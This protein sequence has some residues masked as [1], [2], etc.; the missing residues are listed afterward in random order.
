MEFIFGASLL[1][2][3]KI[4]L[5]AL[6]GAIIGTE[7]QFA[8]KE[9]GIR[10]NSIVAI[11]ACLFS[12]VGLLAFQE[13]GFDPTR[14]ASNV[15]VGMGFIGGGIIIF[16]GNKVHGLTTAAELWV[17]SAIGMAVAFGFYREA[18]TTVLVILALVYFTR[19]FR[20]NDRLGADN[21]SS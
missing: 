21:P 17:S 5:A 3:Q 10:T 19:K 18:I 12:L 2:M 8:H 9:A 13:Y 20:L 7:R 14:V 4:L 15:V 1:S 11:S 6:L 16:M